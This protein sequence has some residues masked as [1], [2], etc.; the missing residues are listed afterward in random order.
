MPEEGELVLATVKKIMPYGAFC[1]LDEYGNTE[2]IPH[3]SS[4]CPPH[5]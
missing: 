1:P 4:T 5:I 3:P 2:A